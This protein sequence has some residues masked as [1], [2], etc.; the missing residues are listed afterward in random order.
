M[1]LFQF[2]AIALL[3][4]IPVAA[5]Q[6]PAASPAEVP[7]T[8]E[9][10]V[11][12]FGVM[13]VHE[14]MR[15][16]MDAMIVQMREMMRDTVK[17]RS[18]DMTEEQFSK[19]EAMQGDMLKSL[20]LDGMLDDMIP[21]YQKHLT[22]S[23]IDAMIAFYSAPT[24][25]KLMREQPEMTAES[26]QA[27]YGRMQKSMDEMLQKAEEMAKDDAAKRKSEKPAAKPEQRKN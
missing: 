12:L 10:V 17:K 2:C 21:V 19:I 15:K 27:M 16:T 25:Q 9:Q 20:D 26:M 6:P 5:Q 11:H 23:D 18:P 8:R 3:G 22:K 13:H 7:A 14:Q 4:A 1:K 24:G